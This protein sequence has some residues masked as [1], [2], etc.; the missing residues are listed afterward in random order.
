[1]SNV[2]DKFVTNGLPISVYRVVSN[3]HK[4]CH[5]QGSEAESRDLR[6]NLTEYA[7]EMRRFLDALRLLEMTYE[8][9]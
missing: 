1:M 4:R 7:D 3:Y 6:T 5:P 9:V 8:E 2:I